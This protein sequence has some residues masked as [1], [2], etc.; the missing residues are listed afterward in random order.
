MSAQY[1][2]KALCE[3]LKGLDVPIS[4]KSD[5]KQYPEIIRSAHSKLLQ[6]YNSVQIGILL[7]VMQYDGVIYFETVGMLNWEENEIKALIHAWLYENDL[8]YS[9]PFDNHPD[10]NRGVEIVRSEKTDVS[11]RFAVKIKF[12]ELLM[13]V[14]DEEGKISI[15]DK[16]YRI[17]NPLLPEENFEAEFLGAT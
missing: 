17:A 1:K 5:I 15:S 11:Y 12:V 13:L 10:L 14:L 3:Y 7:S 9:V 6:Y 4:N 16:K 2:L 8:F